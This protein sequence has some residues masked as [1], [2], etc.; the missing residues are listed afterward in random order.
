MCLVISDSLRG[1]SLQEKWTSAGPASLVILFFHTFYPFLDSL[2]VLDHMI[3]DTPGR[4]SK[5]VTSWCFEYTLTGLVE[6]ESLR[7][8]LTVTRW[9]VNFSYT[10]AWLLSRKFTI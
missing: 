6:N 9:F 7:T 4:G 1:M 2:T 8:Y 3:R 5:C 10:H